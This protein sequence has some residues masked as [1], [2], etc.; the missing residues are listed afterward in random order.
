MK[1]ERSHVD[2]KRRED[3]RIVLVKSFSLRRF[4]Q[5]LLLQEFIFRTEKLNI[6]HNIKADKGL[7]C[8]FHVIR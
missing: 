8:E 3:N 1:R 6:V 4:I 7:S 5:I 2:M